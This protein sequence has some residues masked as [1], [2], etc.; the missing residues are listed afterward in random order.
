LTGA[1][2]TGAARSGSTIGGRFL[3]QA[4]LV[5]GESG[6]FFAAID[7]ATAPQR[8]PTGAVIKI[9]HPASGRDSRVGEAFR[10]EY[11]QARRLSHPNI[12]RVHDFIADPTALGYTLDLPRGRSLADSL[13]DPLAGRVSREYAWAVISAVGAALVHAHLREVVHGALSTRS[14]WLTED[15][16]LRVLE[17]GSRPP[18]AAASQGEMVRPLPW[19]ADVAR[20]A[21]CEVLAGLL[22]NASDDL[23]SLSCLAYELLAGKHP[24]DGAS[25]TSARDRALPLARAPGLKSSAW[26]TLKAGLA[27]SRER[28]PASVREWLAT[29]SLALKDERLPE[30]A[31]TPV[32]TSVR[33]GRTAVIA[34]TAAAALGCLLWARNSMHRDVQTPVLATAGS[35]SASIPTPGSSADAPGGLATRAPSPS[36]E[37]A[38]PF[39]PPTPTP[40]PT[41]SAAHSVAASE[42]PKGPPTAARPMPI[43]GDLWFSQAQYTVAPNSRFVEVRVLRRGSVKDAEFQWWTEADTALDGVD[44][45]AQAPAMQ[46]IKAGALGTSLFIRI[47]ESKVARRRFRVCVNRENSA[48]TPAHACARIMG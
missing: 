14:I 4:L 11:N 25:A 7:S 3:V 35:D 8:P 45:H 17:F 1:P 16:R 6:D 12:A 48:G 43:G 2:E 29:L 18:L 44:F 46:T 19:S 33:M 38:Q 32:P 27:V 31:V 21:S 36:S 13:P 37:S 47:P 42:L 34:V 28:R 30:M 23:Y 5:P 9:A 20:Y 24:W 15:R 41:P 40:T 26:R 22:P 39:V 10:H